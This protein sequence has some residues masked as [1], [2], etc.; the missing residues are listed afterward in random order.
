MDETFQ[1]L[2]AACQAVS[3]SMAARF[4]TECSPLDAGSYLGRR[5]EAYL[6]VQIAF[7]AL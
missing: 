7:H 1:L 3:I 4:L 5:C 6:R 2:H